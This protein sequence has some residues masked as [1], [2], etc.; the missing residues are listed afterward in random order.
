M[1][2]PGFAAARDH[3][4]ER[5]VRTVAMEATGVYTAGAF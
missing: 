5:G 2:E 1:G 4:R 3:L